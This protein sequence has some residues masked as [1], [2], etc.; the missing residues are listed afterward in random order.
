MT[1]DR[2]AFT[3]ILLTIALFTPRLALAQCETDDDC[4]YGRVCRDGRCA[5]P[6]NACERDVDCPEGQV[7]ES[8]TCV[9]AVPVSSPFPSSGADREVLPPP[10]PAVINNI[11]PRRTDGGA[12]FVDPI[13]WG[14][15]GH[16]SP[17]P[18]GTSTFEFQYGSGQVP[19]P[20]PDCGCDEQGEVSSFQLTLGGDSIVANILTIGFSMALFRWAEVGDCPIMSLGDVQMRLSVLAWRHRG[21]NHWFGITPFLRILM[22]AGEGS[23]IWGAG[24]FAM[25]EPGLALGL[26]Y[27]WFSVSLH[28]SG[29]VGFS[30]DDTLGGFL[31]HLSLGVRP[32]SL[33]G[34]I[35]DL[36]VGYGTPADPEAVP[37]ALMAALRLYLGST[38][39]LDV[40]SRFALTESARTS[41]A[42]AAAGLWS[43][44]LRLAVVWRGL[45]RP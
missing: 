6:A 31:S 13:E 16:I 4:R 18:H 14:G 36:E 5:Y 29:L 27:H 15:R 39:A 30:G 22:S 23:S 38:I 24:Y 28:L 20:H 3:A 45:G 8:G 43:V 9:N 40:A 21:R 34:I 10:R 41:D 12:R 44:G 37:V 35:V 25:L 32:I 1:A 7:C 33:L 2:V 42:N 17:R 11:R 26:A 19:C